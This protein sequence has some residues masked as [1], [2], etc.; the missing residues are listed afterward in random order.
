MSPNNTADDG[1]SSDGLSRTAFPATN[2]G[3][4]TP[5]GNMNG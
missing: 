1:V 3:R 5:A 2:A 4:T